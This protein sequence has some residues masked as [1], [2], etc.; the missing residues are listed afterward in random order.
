M[1]SGWMAASSRPGPLALWGRLSPSAKRPNTSAR[2]NDSSYKR[3]SA[4]GTAKSWMTTSV[5][6]LPLRKSIIEVMVAPTPRCAGASVSRATACTGTAKRW[7]AAIMS[8]LT[9][10]LRPSA[11]EK[12]RPSLAEFIKISVEPKAPAARITR[13]ARKV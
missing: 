1:S 11:C 10:K 12:R 5:C 7:A 9:E 3:R 4:A 8:P 2:V 6:G 13:R